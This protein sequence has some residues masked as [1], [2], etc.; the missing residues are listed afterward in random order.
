MYEK[1]VYYQSQFMRRSF[2]LLM[3]SVFFIYS[4]RTTDSDLHIIAIIFPVAALIW[5]GISRWI[6]VKLKSKKID[7][8]I[9]IRSGQFNSYKTVEFILTLAL[10]ISLYGS[11][12]GW[13]YA[14]LFLYMVLLIYL[15]WLVFQVRSLR[16]YFNQKDVVE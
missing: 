7:N 1:A 12:S 9:D 11:M 5:F 3:L 15:A 8:A 16:N 6:G 10:G 14:N 2:L 4:N 13:H